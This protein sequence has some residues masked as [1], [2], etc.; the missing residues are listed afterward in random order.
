VEMS[1]DCVYPHLKSS[2]RVDASLNILQF[3]AKTNHNINEAI[4]TSIIGHSPE[5]AAAMKRRK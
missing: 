3:F 5:M 2:Q 4:M 1:C